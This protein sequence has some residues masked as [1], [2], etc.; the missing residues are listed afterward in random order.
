LE[1][2][3]FP[4]GVPKRGGELAV[5]LRT[6]GER[7]GFPKDVKD[8]ILLHALPLMLDTPLGAATGGLRLRD[9][10][11]A[12]RLDELKF[13]IAVGDGQGVQV[14]GRSLLGTLGAARDDD[15]MPAGY[16]EHVRS[17]NTRRLCGLLTGAIDL[18][19]RAPVGGRGQWFVADY[20]TNTLGPRT[21]GRVVRSTAEHY[22]QPWLQAEIARKHYY[23]QYM[24]YLVALHRYLR[25]RLVDYDYDRDVGG[26]LYLFVR[27]M[28]GA[29]TAEVDGRVHGVFHD[30]PPKQLIEQ[31]SALLR[32]E[33]A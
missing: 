10:A 31:L 25:S 17:M 20:K 5:L 8:G 18:I 19:F 13:D 9:I 32:G 21:D 23:I 22:A 27:G 2:T 28:V 12:E 3:S 4:S 15:P 6:H 11:D 29:A 30:K 33:T 26:A 14:R 16:L 7:A 24:L 1:H